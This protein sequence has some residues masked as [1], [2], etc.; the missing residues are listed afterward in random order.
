MSVELRLFLWF[1]ISFESSQRHLLWGR[2]G[3]GWHFGDNKKPQ[4]TCS[5][6]FYFWSL[7]HILFS[8][9]AVCLLRL[10]GMQA[11]ACL[12]FLSN[13][14]KQGLAVDLRYSPVQLY[15]LIE[16]YHICLRSDPYR[17]RSMWITSPP[18][19]YKVSRPVAQRACS[20]SWL[21]KL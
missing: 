7:D 21:A 6:S 1:R 12:A 17:W 18:F 15:L 14:K 10:I 8:E 16:Q 5:P 3:Q 13:K 4:T 9:F 11:F 19:A 2:E 20:S